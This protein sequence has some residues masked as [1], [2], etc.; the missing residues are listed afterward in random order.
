[1]RKSRRVVESGD[2]SDSP[3]RRGSRSR[4][5]A[6]RSEDDSFT[7]VE[8]KSAKKTRRRAEREKLE[9]KQREEEL[10]LIEAER[11]MDCE[12]LECAKVP[13]KG[14]GKRTKSPSYT[15]AEDC[16]ARDSVKHGTKELYVV[17][18]DLRSG[19]K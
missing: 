14:A 18:T 8:T 3:V 15:G 16:A 19:P 12:M 5:P 7:P 17:C 13:V 11:R 2:E 4:S 10:R 6:K 1:M 9:E